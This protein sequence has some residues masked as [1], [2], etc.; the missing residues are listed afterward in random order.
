MNKFYIQSVLFLLSISLYVNN[1]TI[2]TEPD[3]GKDTTRISKKRYATSE[4]IYEQNNHLLCTDPEEI[5]N[6]EELMNDAVM[7]LVY[8]ATNND[9][10]ELY[11]KCNPSKMAIYKKKHDDHTDVEKTEY[12]VSGSHM[13]NEIINKLWDPT[14]P[15]F[16]NII[17]V[18]RRIVRVY[19]PNLVMIQQLY[20]KKCKSRWKYFYALATKAEISEGTFAFVMT[21][22]NIN[23]GYPSDKE[24][25]NTLIEKANLFKADI[26]SED[27]IRKGKLK[28]AFV[29]ISGYLIEKKGDNLEIIYV[30]SMDERDSIYHMFKNALSQKL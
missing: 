15:C 19:N 26:N 6:A 18:E 12:T 10:Y 29:N 27:D 13:Y 20:K 21:S 11:K 16:F 17:S 3:S 22:A 23:D 7:H 14:H 2:A 9:G 4:E 8:H 1:K 24:Y 28:K 5:K 25:K 30:E